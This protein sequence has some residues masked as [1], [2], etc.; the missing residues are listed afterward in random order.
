MG[1]DQAARHDDEPRGR[2]EQEQQREWRRLAKF[3]VVEGVASEGKAAL[4]GEVDTEGAMPGAREEIAA[5]FAIPQNTIK[6][7]LRR[8]LIALRQCMDRRKTG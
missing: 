5:H 1:G 8:G 4:A 6:T 3:H 7:W 2:D